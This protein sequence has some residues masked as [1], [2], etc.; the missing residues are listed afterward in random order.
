MSPIC[1]EC[2][3]HHL[4]IDAHFLCANLT[5]EV[6]LINVKNSI[7]FL[8]PIFA[9]EKGDEA[10]QCLIP[11]CAH[12]NIFEGGQRHIVEVRFKISPT[13]CVIGCVISTMQA[14]TLRTSNLRPASIIAVYLER[15]VE[16]KFKIPPKLCA[17]GFVI[18]L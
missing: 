13:L 8:F 3:V 6:K 18:Q 5:R 16:V 17:R 1:S 9:S 10:A 7:C 15:P 14:H 2:T 12:R 11:N 4:M